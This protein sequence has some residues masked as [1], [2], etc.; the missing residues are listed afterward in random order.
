MEA[1]LGQFEGRARHA[2][3]AGRRRC[4]R[5]AEETQDRE[6]QP[7]GREHGANHPADEPGLEVRNLGAHGGD[8]RPLLGAQVGDLGREP[9]VEIRDFRPHLGD[10]TGDLGDLT[11]QVS[12]LPGHLSAQC[13]EAGLELVG[14]DL[15]AV[16][17][18]ACRTAFVMAS[19]WAGVNSASVS[20]RATACVSSMCPLYIAEDADTEGASD[21]DA[22]D[23][24]RVAPGRLVSA[25]T[26]RPMAGG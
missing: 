18:A 15:V 20:E 21:C 14:C 4:G 24:R 13:R 16:A 7:G 2:A 3:E 8:V 12:S 5:L 11:R 1:W 9:R 22:P 6:G 23:P 26:P 10:L 25:P 19:A 17:S